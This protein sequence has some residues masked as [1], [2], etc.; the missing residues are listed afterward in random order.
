M[1]PAESRW[2]L[3]MALDVQSHE[4]RLDQ[5]HNFI[6]GLKTI[7]D[8]HN[9]FMDRTLDVIIATRRAVRRLY[10]YL[11]LAMGVLV[12]MLGLLVWRVMH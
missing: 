3:G 11:A 4:H 8:S 7:L 2:F 5:Y 6:D 12:V 1:T 10:T 9:E